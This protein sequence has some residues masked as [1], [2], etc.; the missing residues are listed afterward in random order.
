MN[1]FYPD[2]LVH[3]NNTGIF[4]PNDFSNIINSNNAINNSM[5]AAGLNFS[6]L[7]PMELASTITSTRH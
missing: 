7:T 4:N 5:V 2:N 6:S 1:G 3:G